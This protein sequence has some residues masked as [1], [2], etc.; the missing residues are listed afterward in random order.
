[1]PTSSLAAAVQDIPIG[2][3]IEFD[4]KGCGDHLNHE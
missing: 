3:L 4:Y 1:V 2:E